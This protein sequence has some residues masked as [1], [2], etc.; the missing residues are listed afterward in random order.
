MI[1]LLHFIFPSYSGL[2]PR[3]TQLTSQ[4]LN[5]ESNESY[6]SIITVPT[7]FTISY[8]VSL[9]FIIMLEVFFSGSSVFESSDGVDIIN[10][11]TILKLLLNVIR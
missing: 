6:H 10:N 2:I 11:K 8:Y 4:S 7:Y 3:S 5:S 1:G 9:T